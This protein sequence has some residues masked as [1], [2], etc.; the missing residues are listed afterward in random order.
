MCA[1]AIVINSCA[2]VEEAKDE[3]IQAILEAA[4]LR[5]EGSDGAGPKKVVV[6]GCMAQR[7]GEELAEGLPEVDLVMGF[8]NYQGLPGALRETLDLDPAEGGGSVERRARAQ[9][10]DAAA[11]QPFLPKVSLAQQN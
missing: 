7:Y 1:D 2:F 9:S 8:E 3:S 6:S 4:R 5:T 11:M 10:E